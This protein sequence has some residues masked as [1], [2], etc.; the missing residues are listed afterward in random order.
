MQRD[1]LA[2][3]VCM[4]SSRSASVAACVVTS[5]ASCRCLSLHSVRLPDVEQHRLASDRHHSIQSATSAYAHIPLCILR[6]LSTAYAILRSV[7]CMNCRCLVPPVLCADHVVYCLCCTTE[8]T[9]SSYGASTSASSSSSS[10]RS[11]HYNVNTDWSYAEPG[12]RGYTSTISELHPIGAHAS[13]VHIQH[14]R[15]GDTS[16][17]IWP[18]QLEAPQACWCT[19]HE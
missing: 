4:S 8:R 19:S 7:Y 15:G 6:E 9:R 12:S 16:L 1:K 2:A 11:Y 14:A 5:G 13:S 3:P 18:Q 10:S 17:K